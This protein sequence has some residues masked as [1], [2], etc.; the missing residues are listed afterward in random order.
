[1]FQP[2]RQRLLLANLIVFALVLGGFAGAVRLVFWR[3]LQQ[4]LINQLTTLGQSA[5]AS[6]EYG[7]GRLKVEDDLAITELQRQQQTLQWFD[8]QGKLVTQQGSLAISLPL[9]PQTPTQVQTTDPAIQAVTLPIIDS[10]TGLQ[11][12]YVRVSQSLAEFNNTM[13]QLDWGLGMGV[14]VGLGISGAG[15]LWL[16]RQAMA[17]IEASFQQLKQFT[18]DASHELRNPLMAI[19]SNAEVVLKY[20]E[21]MRA[22]DHD[23]FVAI[24]SATAQMTKLTED[25]LLLARSDR[26]QRAVRQP[27]PISTLLTNLVS[28][29]QPQA[30]A[31]AITLTSQIAPGL[32]IWGEPDPITRAL[33]NLLQNA[34][35]Y[36]PTG[37][38][39]E[40]VA[41]SISHQ[42]QIA[43]Q[44]TGIGIAPA[45]QTRVFERFWR[46]D[47]AR[48]HDHSGSGLGLAITQAIVTQHGGTITLKSQPGQGS[49]F[50][51][52]LPQDTAHQPEASINA[53]LSRS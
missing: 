53:H 16:N 26:Q 24:I 38:Q 45:D 20:P 8:R 49:C 34:L 48:S 6:V 46:A 40:V 52:K 33:T 39:V 2:I 27:L 1:M 37:G 10:D 36:T 51:V 4:Q 22:G 47:T 30:Q 11:I 12:G 7:A 17:P 42:V 41:Q 18:A 31:R 35:Q 13:S 9:T 19:S 44:D 43:V 14:L 5:A 3:N 21:G 15:I 29:Y 50:T 32:M 25:L 23:A 28:L